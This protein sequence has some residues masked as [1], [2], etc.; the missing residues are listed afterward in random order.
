MRKL[1]LGLAT[2]ALCACGD[3]GKADRDFVANCQHSGFTAEQCGF[4]LAMSKKAADDS[5]ATGIMA[6]AA[7]GMSTV[8]AMGRK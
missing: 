4:L 5:A 2:L 8:N 7:M 1:L 3:D 6:G